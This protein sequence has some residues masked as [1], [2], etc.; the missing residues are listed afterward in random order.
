[1]KS[2]SRCSYDK[3]L[4]KCRHIFRAFALKGKEENAACLAQAKEICCASCQYMQKEQ[5][6]GK[7][8]N[9][10]SMNLEVAC[11]CRDPDV[12]AV[13]N[14]V[15]PDSAQEPGLIALFNGMPSATDMLRERPGWCPRMLRTEPIEI[16]ASAAKRLLETYDDEVPGSTYRPI[17]MFYTQE[18]GGYVGIDN[19]SGDALVEEFSTR[20]DCLTWLQGHDPLYY[21]P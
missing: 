12:K 1:M 2:T 9:I 15:L 14:V 7:N 18:G 4:K 16:D 21:L 19:M 10:P 13:F 20:D 3:I 6:G 17:G 11:F 5:H 8:G